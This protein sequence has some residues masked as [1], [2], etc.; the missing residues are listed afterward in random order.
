MKHA[1]LI[2]K[3]QGIVDDI[4]A[5]VKKAAE[6]TPPGTVRFVITNHVRAKATAAISILENDAAHPDVVAAAVPP[7]AAAKPATTTK[8]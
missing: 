1:E 2:K 8:S 3:F 6:A 4:D 5:E 7:P